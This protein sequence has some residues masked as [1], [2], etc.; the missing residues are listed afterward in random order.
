MDMQSFTTVTTGSGPFTISANGTIMNTGNVDLRNIKITVYYKDTLGADITN[1]ITAVSAPLAIGG[2]ASV[3]IPAAIMG[4]EPLFFSVKYRADFDRKLENYSV[5]A[6]A[7]G[8][9]IFATGVYFICDYIFDISDF[10]DKNDAKVQLSAV[11]D[12]FSLI[13]S[14][15][16]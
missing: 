11:N 7:V 10:L 6:G 4:P 2:S 1:T 12:G 3:P 15:R 16:F 14:K 13:T 9:V 5:P 8:S